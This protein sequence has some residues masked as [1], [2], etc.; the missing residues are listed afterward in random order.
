MSTRSRSAPGP[1]STREHAQRAESKAIA[2]LKQLR[3]R[4]RLAC[5]E[6]VRANP[7]D[8]ETVVGLAFIMQR[9]AAQSPRPNSL[10]ARVRRAGITRLSEVKQK[11]PDLRAQFSKAQLINAISKANR[12]K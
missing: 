2:L 9:R 1:R 6:Y 7:P 11:A 4:N 5:E 10:Q 12:Q 8:V 3:P